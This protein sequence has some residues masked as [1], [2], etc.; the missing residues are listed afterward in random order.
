MQ[1]LGASTPQFGFWTERNSR[2]WH[3]IRYLLEPCGLLTVTTHLKENELGLD[4]Q[5]LIA[6]VEVLEKS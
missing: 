5:T 4:W 1:R 2:L 6:H 3:F